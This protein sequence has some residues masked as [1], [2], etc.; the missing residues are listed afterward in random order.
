M[1]H[2]LW[3]IAFLMLT[4]SP[5]SAHHDGPIYDNKKEVVLSGTVVAWTLRNP[6]SYFK[7]SVLPP[8]GGAEEWSIEGGPPT[9]W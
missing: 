2:A 3:M 4:L 9:V 5:L 8:R 1:R 6:H 7:F